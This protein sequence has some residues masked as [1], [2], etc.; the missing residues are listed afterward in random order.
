MQNAN[1]SQLDTVVDDSVSRDA[2]THDGEANR[3]SKSVMMWRKVVDMRG[4]FRSSV[5]AWRWTP[6][7]ITAVI[8]SFAVALWHAEAS[9]EESHAAGL[10]KLATDSIRA[11]IIDDI[12]ARMVDLGHIAKL[13]SPGSHARWQQ[14]Q[15]SSSQFTTRYPECLGVAWVSSSNDVEWVVRPAEDVDLENMY[16]THDAARQASEATRVTRATV[17]SQAIQHH[18]RKIVSFWVPVYQAGEL[19]GSLV[20]VFWAE[21]MLNAVL[22]DSAGPD[23]SVAIS[24]GAEPFYLLRADEWHRHATDQAQVSFPGTEWRVTVWRQHES[25]PAG[26]PIS[27]VLLI[28]GLAFALM[29]G[30]IAH[31]ARRAHLSADRLSE[32]NQEL[33]REVAARRRA[34]ESLHVLSG[35][36]MK[37]QDEERQSLARILHEGMAQ[38]LFA[39]SMNLKLSCKVLSLSEPQGMLQQSIDLADECVCE[40]RALTHLLHPP[41]LD[42][43]GLVA[44]CETFVHGFMERS[45]IMVT[46]ECADEPVRFPQDMEMALF[47]IVQ[48]SLTT[49]QRHGTATHASIR[50]AH[51]EGL[52]VLEIKSDDQAAYSSDERTGTAMSVAAMRER[53]WQLG[54]ELHVDSNGT[55]TVL[56]ALL[57]YMPEELTSN[58]TGKDE[59]HS[60]LGPEWAAIANRVSS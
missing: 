35:R 12:G 51:D 9:Q 34:E 3:H 31:L 50:L 36:L 1:R 32:A 26:Q 16:F 58:S 60:F 42:V 25:A 59:S 2:D 44:A 18:N 37:V 8:F 20:G 10:L 40:M 41:S 48:E 39:L 6:A 55:G 22:A 30:L 15:T 56:R 27:K 47:R 21:P 13:W 57:P 33:R 43:L 49:V 14:L 54:G 38:K 17:V 29:A 52:V 7:L 28:A 11:D 46:M 4:R 23:Y 45:G 19:Q 53:L 5:L 24:D